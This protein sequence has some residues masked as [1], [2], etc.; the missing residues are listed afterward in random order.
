MIGFEQIAAFVMW[1]C[2]AGV[3]YTYV[4]YPA[5]I[6]LF[7]RVMGSQ[8]SRRDLS[9]AELPTVSLLIAAYN[10]QANIGARVDNAL[11]LDYPASKLEI[12]I[13]S[14]GSS[15]ATN[16]I[17]RAR[18]D[19]RVRLLAYRARRG[20]AAV[21][22]SAMRELRGDIVVL[23]DANTDTD[24]AAI[25]KLV[26]WF[27]SPSVG[28]VSGRLVLIDGATGTNVDGMYWKYETFLKKCESRL[29]ALLG[30]NGGIYAIRRALYTG[31]RESTLIDDFVIPLLMRLRSGCA[32]VYET[33]AV[34]YEETPPQISAEFTRRARI[35]TGGFQ[36]MPV[37]WRLLDPSHGWIA[38]T[39]ASHKIARWICPFLLLGAFAANLVLV[40]HPVYAALLAGQAAVYAIAAMGSRFTGQTTAARCVRL[41]TLFTGMN[42]ALLV[43]FWRWV[44]TE[45]QGAWTRTART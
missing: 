9:D 31:I 18:R 7:A 10:E 16:E 37:L 13:A 42:L 43:G 33:E 2:V 29:G 30:A 38:F 27:A 11:R 5:L 40:L 12:V 28:V 44:T 6:W 24:P 45:P 17:V 41:A 3:V 32:I 8:A 34:A 20:K 15:D 26:R 25:R 21:L 22:N 23:S 1:L 4:L 39:F 35:G 36:S 14:D 19:P